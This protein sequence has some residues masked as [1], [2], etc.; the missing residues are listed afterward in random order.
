MK[1]AKNTIAAGVVSLLLVSGI[2]ATPA[3]AAPP[4]KPNAPTVCLWFPWLPWC[5]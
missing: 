2:A 1:R 3:Q 5:P 4:V